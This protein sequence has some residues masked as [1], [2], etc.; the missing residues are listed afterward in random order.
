MTDTARHILA[1]VRGLAIKLDQAA[2]VSR[3]FTDFPGS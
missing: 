1:D 3:F 2:E